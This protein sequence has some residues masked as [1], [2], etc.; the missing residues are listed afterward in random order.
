MKEVSKK[1]HSDGRIIYSCQYHVI[2]CPKYRKKVLVDGVDNRLKELVIEKQE[3]YGYEVMEMEVMSD[4]VHLFLD[5]HP[6]NS[7][8]NIVNMIKGY[9]SFKLRKEFPI[10]KIK[11]WKGHLRTTSKFIS[12]VG[13][14]TLDVVKKYIEEQ[15]E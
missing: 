2:F 7:V 12:S 1:Y 5:I 8:E 14:A 13:T 3:Q 11:L 10:L 9:T 6:K 15:K 4:H